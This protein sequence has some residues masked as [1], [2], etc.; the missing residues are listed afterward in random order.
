MFSRSIVQILKKEELTSH[1][2]LEIFGWPRI[3]IK[4]L[5]RVYAIIRRVVTLIIIMKNI[6]LI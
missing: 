3:I 2:F 5:F 1:L 4:I 6:L